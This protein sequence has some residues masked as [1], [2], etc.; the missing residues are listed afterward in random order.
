MKLRNYLLIPL[1]CVFIT[2][3]GY[4]ARIEQKKMQERHEQESGVMAAKV[5]KYD[6][7]DAVLLGVGSF[8]AG[9]VPGGAGILVGLK[10]ARKGYMNGA[11]VTSQSVLDAIAAAREADPEFDKAFDGTAGEVLKGEMPSLIQELYAA[12]RADQKAI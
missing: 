10:K 1:A 3:C 6:A 5:A 2:G 7:V 11:E 9:S 12:Y 8:F 4:S